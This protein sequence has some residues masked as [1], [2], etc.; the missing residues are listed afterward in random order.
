MARDLLWR[1]IDG[2]SLGVGQ[3]YDR[4]ATVYVLRS[5]SDHSVVPAHRDVLNKI[6]D[7]VAMYLGASRMP[8]IRSEQSANMAAQPTRTLPA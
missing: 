6:G 7:T 2:N 3:R 8:L 5:L 4:V 1:A